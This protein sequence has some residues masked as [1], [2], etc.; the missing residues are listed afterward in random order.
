MALQRLFIA[1]HLDD[2]AISFGGSLLAETEK[3]P[4]EIR[5]LAATVFSR[6]NFTK[7]GLGN[8]AAV[9]PIRK[10][11]EKAVMGSVEV[12]TLF[13][14]FPECP[15]RGYAISHTLDYPRW[16]DPELDRDTV[17]RL[18]LCFKDLFKNSDEVLAPLAFGDWAHVDHRIVR[19]ATS[20]AW[21]ENPQIPLRLYED[22]P[23]I[24]QEIRDRFS[25]LEG[26]RLEESSIDLEAKLGLI[27]GYRSQPIESWE[28]LIRRA[29]GHPPRERTWAIGKPSALENLLLADS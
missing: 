22:V 5:T 27:K 10:A 13:L 14:D 16:I 26:V 23:Y 2:T 19:Q 28:E 12:D 4:R 3:R 11:E 15:L 1:P 29:A 7:E 17:E 18:A 9:T 24:G 8:E 21:K 25:A 6:S 20:L